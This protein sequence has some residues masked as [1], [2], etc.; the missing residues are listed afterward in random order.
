MAE[1]IVSKHGLSNT[2]L[3]CWFILIVGTCGLAYPL[4]A[5]RKHA[6]ERKTVTRVR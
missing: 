1:K 6:A 3:S 2:E 4:Y 5:M